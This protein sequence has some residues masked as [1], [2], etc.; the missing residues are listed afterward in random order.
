MVRFQMPAIPHVRL[1]STLLTVLVPL[2]PFLSAR[3]LLE[4]SVRV[5]AMILLKM[6]LIKSCIVD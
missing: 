4:S 2:P 1:V 6:T 5:L 3:L